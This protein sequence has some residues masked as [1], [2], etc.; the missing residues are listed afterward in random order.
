MKVIC[1]G[2][3]YNVEYMYYHN[4]QGVII[5]YP[6]SLYKQNSL[7][8]VYIPSY[9][10][11]TKCGHYLT[12]IDNSLNYDWYLIKIVD[13]QNN[14]TKILKELNAVVGRSVI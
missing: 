12:K 5:S 11:Y 6:K 2:V 10:I 14:Y 4:R 3:E 1:K 8:N 13:E 9:I 7:T